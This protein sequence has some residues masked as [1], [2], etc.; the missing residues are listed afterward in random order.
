MTSHST[1]LLLAD[2]VRKIL[3]EACAGNQRAWADRHG[4]SP[5]HVTNVL[6]NHREPQGKIL[7]ALGLERVVIYCARAD[8]AAIKAQALSGVP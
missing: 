3:L 1:K 5:Q 4:V 2:D 8:R 7:E 6:N